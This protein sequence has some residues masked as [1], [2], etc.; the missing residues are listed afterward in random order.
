MSGGGI[1][2]FLTPLFLFLW[3]FGWSYKRL[4]GFY[5]RLGGVMGGCVEL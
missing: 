4:S 2:G 5:E 3:D 1:F